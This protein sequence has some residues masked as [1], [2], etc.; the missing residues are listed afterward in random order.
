MR[1][2]LGFRKR[3]HLPQYKT[4]EE[5]EGL[6]AACR[7][8]A[9][10]LDHLRPH[11]QEGVTTL[12]IDKLADEYT[13]DH[14][15][16]PACYGYKGYPKSICT[17]INDVICHGIPDDR[18]L[19]S[20]DIVNVDCTT[21]VD[22]WYGDQSETFM[23]GDVSA[24]AKRIVQGAFDALWI[25]I[26]ALEPYCAVIEIGKAIASF[27][28]EHNFGVVENFQGHGIGRKFHQ[29]PGV[30]HIPMPH[31]RRDILAPGVSFTIEPMLNLGHQDTRGPLSDG[32]TVL[33]K[34][35]TLSA[36]FEHQILMTDN[37]PEVMT[38]TK[39]GPQEG[40]QF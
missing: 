19:Q 2:L 36:Q 15:H 33:T 16:I 14:G 23:I 30:P 12:A 25:G 24:N 8:N 17:S 5:R 13:R 7:F 10:L 34:D 26:R 31:T 40:H 27:G 4:E 1:R 21:I 35:G 22:G 39:N 3:S 37:G 28:R 20:G 9:S 29:D 6:R 11:V 38:L 18:P 32:W